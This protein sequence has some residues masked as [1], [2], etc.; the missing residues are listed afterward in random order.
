[1]DF[2]L[3]KAIAKFAKLASNT[4]ICIVK[5]NERD[6]KIACKDKNSLIN[7]SVIRKLE[8][9]VRADMVN[10]QQIKHQADIFVLQRR[11]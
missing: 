3:K 2:L 1:M 5:E 11:Y 7:M 4:N 6:L 10:F 8:K 9:L